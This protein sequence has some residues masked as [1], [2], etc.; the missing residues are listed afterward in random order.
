MIKALLISLLTATLAHA[1][2]D[3]RTADYLRAWRIGAAGGELW[4]PAELGDDLALW[5][6]ASDAS[7]LWADT[8]ATTA[9]TNNGT[10]ARWD[11]KSGN[12][13]NAVQSTPGAR[14]T[15]LTDT[16]STDGSD[17]LDVVKGGEIFRNVSNASLIVVGKDS[18]PTGGDNLHMPVIFFTNP[19]Q[20]L[21]RMHIRTRSAS[22]NFQAFGRRLDADTQVSTSNTELT[23]SSHIMIAFGDYSSGFLRSALDGSDYN[24]VAYSS[25]SGS[26]SDT[27]GG[28]AVIF[29]G[30]TPGQRMPANSTI[31]EVI[32]VYNFSDEIKEKIEGYL[33]HKW[34]LTEKLPSD[35]PYKNKAPRKGE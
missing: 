14:P 20:Q 2:Y 25:G 11:D 32:C 4:T 7:T 19:N 8:N 22:S 10:V 33:A 3:A 21:G 15:L 35:H 18:D 16:L 6:D 17:Q 5:L 13:R 27:D 12:D 9:A 30:L 23:T 29:R 24:S 26:T 1:Q 28:T 31:S 34:G